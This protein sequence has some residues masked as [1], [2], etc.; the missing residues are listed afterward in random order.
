MK[1]SALFLSLLVSSIVF[2][3]SAKLAKADTYYEKLAYA[4]SAKLYEELLGSEVDGPQLKSKLAMCYYKIGQMDKAEIFF[5]QMVLTDEAS[6]NDYYYYAQT[7]K[8]NGNYAESDEWMARF[9]KK[10]D[11]DSRGIAYSENTDYL[12]TIEEQEPLFSIKHLEI[13][14]PVSDFGGYYT[15]DKTTA[16]FVSARTKK[17]FV[18]NEW[19]WNRRYFLDLYTAKTSSDNEMSSPKKVSKVNTK[20]HEGPLCFSPD[21]KY[22][23]FTRNNLARK[24]RDRKDKNG[25]RNLKLYRAPIASSG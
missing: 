10:V 1:I 15:S 18:K 13:N 16:Y 23:Y 12:K 9:H 20:Y 5:R 17:A 4:Y 3:Q 25:I 7:L 14:S 21:G 2:G 8:Q 11:A 19:A 24:K 6:S 22:V